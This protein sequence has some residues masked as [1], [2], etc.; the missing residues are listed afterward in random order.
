[1]IDN[2]RHNDTHT[3]TRVH[4]ASCRDD[5][6]II[7]STLFLNKKERKK[8][9]DKKPARSTNKDTCVCVYNILLTLKRGIWVCAY[10]TTDQ[11]KRGVW[12]IA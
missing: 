5:S 6:V 8:N 7:K 11:Q 9:P 10:T 3:P 2:D 1:M 4:T 12:L